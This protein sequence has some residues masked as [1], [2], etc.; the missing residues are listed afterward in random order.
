MTIAVEILRSTTASYHV[1]VYNN[2]VVILIYNIYIYLQ[3]CVSIPLQ[4]CCD[5]GLFVFLRELL[6]AILPP[7]PMT[8]LYFILLQQ[9]IS[10]SVDSIFGFFFFVLYSLESYWQFGFYTIIICCSRLNNYTD[11]YLRRNLI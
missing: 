8:H 6:V 9:F 5:V 2:T 4:F 7:P 10:R 3:Y 11:W 1:Q